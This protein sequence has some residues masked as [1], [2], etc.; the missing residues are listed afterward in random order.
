MPMKPQRL[1]GKE[2]RQSLILRRRPIQRFRLRAN[3]SKHV[4]ETLTHVW[5][6]LSEVSCC[7]KKAMLAAAISMTAKQKGDTRSQP[8]R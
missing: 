5:L 4:V 1:A 2:N 8:C 7:R 6:R 3:V